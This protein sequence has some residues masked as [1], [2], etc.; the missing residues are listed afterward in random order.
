MLLVCSRSFSN[1]LSFN[2]SL[3]SRGIKIVVRLSTQVHIFIFYFYPKIFCCIKYHCR[4]VHIYPAL[5][6]SFFFFCSTE[7]VPIVFS[8]VGF[9]SGGISCDARCLPERRKISCNFFFF[10]FFFLCTASIAKVQNFS[11]HFVML[12]QIGNIQDTNDM[13]SHFKQSNT[14][15]RFHTRNPRP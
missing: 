8:G 5:R 3:G 1:G 6:F 14:F 12:R 4:A 13:Q 7:T 2:I 9:V 10:L 15:I 11:I